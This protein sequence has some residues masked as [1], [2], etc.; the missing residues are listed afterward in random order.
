MA[1]SGCCNA[2]NII[3]NIFN[4]TL[5]PLWCY[6]CRWGKHYNSLL[7]TWCQSC[8]MNRADLW[9]VPQIFEC[10]FL[11]CPLFFLKYDGTF[12][13]RSAVMYSI[14]QLRGH[15]WL[16]AFWLMLSFYSQVFTFSQRSTS[17]RLVS[18]Q[19]HPLRLLEV[20]SSSPSF[21][22]SLLLLTTPHNCH[23][24]AMLKVPLGT[25]GI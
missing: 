17:W 8:Y 12:H 4:I 5:K 11:F 21:H 7:H 13:F 25:S 6:S 20:F 19:N 15:S 22:L 14:M 16:T 24:V 3:L 1:V 23:I 18:S 9:S 10:S 2:D